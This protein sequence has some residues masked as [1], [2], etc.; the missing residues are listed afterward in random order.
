[1]VPV[2]KQSWAENTQK[3]KTCVTS[4][5]THRT[6]VHKHSRWHSEK[7]L[8]ILLSL[9][10]VRLC[11]SWRLKH[12]NSWCSHVYV[13]NIYSPMTSLIQ[14]FLNFLQSSLFASCLSYSLPL[15]LLFC[16]HPELPHFLSS[17]PLSHIC[18]CVCLHIYSYIN[19]TYW[20]HFVMLICICE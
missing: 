1:M 11:H 8:T 13:P 9:A 16:P 12:W 7:S 17:P 5:C 15:Q 4:L 20:I 10:W 14:G 19:T 2:G 18:V 3:E 6:V